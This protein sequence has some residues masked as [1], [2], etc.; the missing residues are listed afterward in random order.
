MNLE[1]KVVDVLNNKKDKKQFIDLP[2]VLY[3]DDSTWVPPLKLAIEDMLS[4]KHPFYETGKVKAWIA[5]KDGQAVGRIM[6]INN[7]NHNKFHEENCG[8]YGFFE[9]VNDVEVFKILLDTAETWVKEEGLSEI[10][11]PVNL[12]TNYECGS[13]IKGFDD[14]P[15]IMMTYNQE[16]HQA[17]K[18][19]LGYT[20]S[21]DLLAYNMPSNLDL[22]EIMH[23]ISARIEKSSR[24]TYRTI[25]KK[26]WAQEV[27][28]ML[29]IY[30]DAWEKNWGFVPMTEAEFRATAKELKGVVDEN[31]IMF[32]EVHGKAVGFIV[33]LPDFHQVF[34]Q[35]PTG[36]L[37]PFG[38]FKL[39][40]PKK[41]ITRCRVITM[42]IKSEY[43]RL[44]LASLLYKKMQENIR[45]YPQYKEI[46]MS[47][48]LEDNL[49]MNK[50]LITMKA[51]PYKTY[52][53]YEK[54]L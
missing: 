31:L 50:P 51:N 30:N 9:S 2:W 40:T 47:W 36:K 26:K 25:N 32:A 44:G 53:I 23:K 49:E 16:Y 39:L 42:G 48:V 43:R 41:Y 20:K 35:I 45:K 19:K 46:E 17:H 10:R 5:F 29:D 18:E 13:L 6:A 11:G 34:K 38:I 4:P 37:F 8:F 21:M 12:S 7:K 15:Q 27:D 14:S 54:A 52:R 28:L 24:I 1:V 3:K 33:T 22:P